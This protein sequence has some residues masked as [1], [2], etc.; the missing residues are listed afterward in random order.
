MD[1]KPRQRVVRYLATIKAGQLVYPLSVERFWRAVDA[2]LAEMSLPT[3]QLRA[4]EGTIGETVPRPDPDVLA[5]TRAEFEAW[6]MGGDAVM[7]GFVGR[8]RLRRRADT[9][10]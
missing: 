2:R 4:I 6:K 10:A 7:Q 9:R 1:G 3:E 5:R 8:R